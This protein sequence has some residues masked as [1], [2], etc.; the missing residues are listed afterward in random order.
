MKKIILG[1]VCL[2]AGCTTLF[3]SNNTRDTAVVYAAL[4]VL[5]TYV[6]ANVVEKLKAQYGPHLYSI[7]CIK[8]DDGQVEYCV[9]KLDSGVMKEEKVNEVALANK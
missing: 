2:V 5:E 3:A 9:R 8:G 6:P 1:M 4:P 7:T